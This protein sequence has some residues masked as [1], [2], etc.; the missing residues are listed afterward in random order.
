VIAV[1]P[2]TKQPQGVI[3]ILRL[4]RGVTFGNHQGRKPIIADEISWPSSKGKTKYNGNLDFVTT[5]AGQ[6]HN[7]GILM[8]LLAKDRKS[9]GLAGFD[10]YEWAGE[11]HKNALP[12]E[13]AGLLKISGDNYIEKP[14]YRVFRAKALALEHCKRKGATARICAKRG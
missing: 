12:F 9:L 8:N 6:A 7:L 1:H 13:F 3:S 14:A 2:Y 10:Y 5:E 4:V 11:E